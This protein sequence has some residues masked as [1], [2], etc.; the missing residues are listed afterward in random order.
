MLVSILLL[1]LAIGAVSA[2]DENITDMT[3]EVLSTEPADE[4]EVTQPEDFSELVTLI[5]G[6]SSGKTLTL[7]KDYINDGTYTKGILISKKMTIDGQG[8]TL[9]ANQ[10]SNI[11]RISNDQVILKNINFINTYH[12]TYSAVYGACTI[13]NC[14]FTDC[15]SEK[16]GGAIYQGTAYNSSFI[17]CKAYLPELSWEHEDINWNY[18]CRGGA[19]YNGDAYNCTFMNC[20]AKYLYYDGVVNIYTKGYG[21]AIYDGN[22]YDCSF[23]KCTSVDGGAVVGNVTNC[24]FINCSVNNYG[25]AIFSGTAYNSSFMNCKAYRSEDEFDYYDSKNHEA[26]KGGA[27]YNGNAYNCSFKTCIAEYIYQDWEWDAKGYGGAIYQG[28]AYDCSFSECISVDGGAIYQG[29]AHN[30]SFEKCFGTSVG[31]SVGFGGAINQGDAFNCSFVTCHAYSGGAIYDG[32]A[33]NS[34]FIGCYA[35]DG[36]T[37][38]GSGGAISRGDSYNCYFECCS[39]GSGSAIYYG[40]AL[41]CSFV[42]CYNWQYGYGGVIYMGNVSDSIFINCSSSKKNLIIKGNYNNCTFI[43][44]TLSSS[45]LTV[46]YGNG[47]KLPIKTLS[48]GINIEGITVNVKIYKDNQLINSFSAVSGSDLNIDAA[49]GKYIIALACAGADPLNVSLVVNKGSPKL[50][51]A[52]DF[53]K[54]GETANV[55]VTMSKKST[56]FAR[57]TIN[58][59]TYRVP[60]S[61]GV[62]SVDIPNLADGSY[63]VKVTYGGNVYFNAET[64]TG[65]FH[66]GKFKQGMQLETQNITVGDTER[67]TAKLAKDATGFVRFIIG[68]DTYKVA[69]ENGVAYVDIDDLTVGTYSVTLK[70]GGN[71]KY[72]VESITETFNVAKPSPGLEFRI[73]H[74][75]Y[76]IGASPEIE[77]HLA[78]DT[79]GFVRFIIGNETYKVQIGNGWASIK[80]SS[81]KAGLYNLIVKYAGNYKYRAETITTSFQVGKTTPEIQIETTNIKVGETERITANLPTD[82]TGFVRFIIGE[83]TYKVQLKKGVAYVDIAD[84]KAGTYSVT[85]KYAGNYKYNA[86][87]ETASFTVSK[88]SPGISVAKTTVG[89]KTVLTASI[90]ADARG[91]INFNVKGNTYKAQIVNGVATVTLP[92]MAPGTYTLKTSYGGNYKYLAETKTRSITIK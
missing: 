83:D 58:G 37:I 55:K 34:S 70:Y 89:G 80:L 27:I 15:I 32:N 59:E 50:T 22:A 56:G 60:I 86:K 28:N 49:P 72:N 14:T 74:D 52:N 65:T 43:P 7:D 19:I 17:N 90:A 64:I 20:E 13:I 66:V 54:S 78:S 87:T 9:D 21:G 5:K 91:N 6:T 85:V 39:A 41:N 10:K 84:L 35:Y 82:T 67:I 40:N 36:P 62:A 4:L 26:C 88:I 38:A 75:Y 79:T 71:Y 77:V 18:V 30:S 12:A 73:V 31:W 48:N 44:L 57:I 23:I 29:D 61:S 47:G 63:A 3:D 33:Y 68:E 45:N 25:G 69:I 16:D 11:F 42:E 24:S 51:L 1:I 8:H 92:D 46:N 76:D 81:L 2:A 53:A